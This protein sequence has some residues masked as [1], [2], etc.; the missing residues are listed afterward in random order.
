MT[1][2]ASLDDIIVVSLTPTEWFLLSG[3][4]EAKGEFCGAQHGKRRYG[5]R[6]RRIDALAYCSWLSFTY[7][8][9]SN[10]ATATRV[11]SKLLASAHSL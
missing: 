1:T 8:E 5:L 10:K 4:L 7:Y 11:R 6:I 3:L 9:G 2:G